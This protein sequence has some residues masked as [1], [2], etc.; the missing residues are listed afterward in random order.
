MTDYELALMRGR[1]TVGQRHGIAYESGEGD[2][3]DPAAPQGERKKELAIPSG[4]GGAD[5]TWPSRLQNTNGAT[6]AAGRRAV[7]PHGRI[8]RNLILESQTTTTTTTTT[9]TTTTS[10]ALQLDSILGQSSVGGVA[11]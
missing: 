10:E 3:I 4:G 1:R 5:I 11:F 6:L 2:S 8:L 7:V 9:A